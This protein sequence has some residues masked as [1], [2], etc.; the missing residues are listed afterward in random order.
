[1]WTYRSKALKTFLSAGILCALGGLAHAQQ[2][3]PTTNKDGSIGTVSGAAQCASY[4]WPTLAASTAG[5]NMTMTVT[6]TEE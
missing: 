1:M 2:S 5:M 6:W 4:S 3:F